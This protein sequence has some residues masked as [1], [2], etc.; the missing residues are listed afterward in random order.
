MYCYKCGAAITAEMKFCPLCGVNLKNTQAHPDKSDDADD[1]EY[2]N[3]A[4][5]HLYEAVDDTMF[6]E[7]DAELIYD[8]L[9][10][11]LRF[12]SFGDY[13]KRYIYTKFRFEESF[14]VIDL[15]EYQ[16]MI[17]KSFEITQTPASFTPTTAKLSALSKNWLTQQTVKRNVVFLLGFGLGMSVDD[18]NLFLTKALREYEINPKNPFEVICWYCYKFGY[19]FDKFT[20][21]WD[22]YNNS[23]K[24]VLDPSLLYTT[25]T[26]AIRNNMYSV[27]N[28][29]T[30]FVH[31]SKLKNSDNTTQSSVTAKE[32]FNILYDKARAIVADLYNQSE[33]ERH[34][35]GLFSFRERLSNNDRLYDYEKAEKI[36]IFRKKR[37]IYTI[38]DISESDIEH[39]ICSAIPT[40]KHGN[41]TPSKVSKLNAQ[42]AGKRFSRQRISEVLSE[43]SEITRFDLIT[44]NFFIFSRSLSQYPDPKQR[45][46]EFVD[47]TNHILE[48]CSMGELYVQNPYECFVQMCILSLDPLG[49]YADVWEL[50]Y[51][52]DK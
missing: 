51:E 34:T 29:E 12:I 45:Y 41:L 49:T 13:L 20:E 7:Q 1:I 40:D 38:K 26:M 11:K 21:L 15:S 16:R 22:I 46:I 25:H 6:L 5:E 47:S 18:V 2:T 52:P 10:H 4:W 35:A 23:P 50:S 27:Y 43:K 39:V 37:R 28:E 19:G 31:L 24:H 32:Y 30:L 44:L 33:E 3:I 42:F 14:S 36:E 48:K 17:K 9:K 8:S